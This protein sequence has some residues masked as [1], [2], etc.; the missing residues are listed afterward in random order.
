LAP[1]AKAKGAYLVAVTSAEDGKGG[2]LGRVCDMSV[3]LPLSGEVCPFGLA[4]V[5]SASVQMVFGDT[6]VAALME[7]K[8]VSREQYASNHPAGRIGK[9]LIFK[10]LCFIFCLFLLGEFGV[11]IVCPSG[12]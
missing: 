12:D 4:P 3:H 10:V 11:N 7:A 1:C 5:T 2:M 6:V 9:S 8:R